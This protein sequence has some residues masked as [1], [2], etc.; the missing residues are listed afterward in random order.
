MIRRPSICTRTDTL[1]PYTALLLS[2]AEVVI[3]VL[4]VVIATDTGA[5]FSGRAIGGPKIAPKISPSKT[6]AGLFGGA[7]GASLAFV[8]LAQGWPAFECWRFRQLPIEQQ[9][10]FDGDRKSTRLNSSH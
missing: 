2:P 9:F 10:G 8:G 1:F 3:C 5:Y 7:L 6:W 4:A